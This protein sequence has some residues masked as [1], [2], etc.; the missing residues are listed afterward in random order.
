MGEKFKG[1]LGFF[2]IRIYLAI[3]VGLNL[4]VWLSAY[5]INKNISDD[6]AILHYNVDF[7][8]NLIGNARQIYIIPLLGLIIIL[9]NFFLF[10]A[11]YQRGIREIGNQ[12]KFL[13]NILFAAAGTANLFLFF[14][15]VSIYLINFF[16]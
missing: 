14:S 5:I 9:F 8:A 16:K 12:D 10:F 7:G 2:Y 1:L 15:L 4:L 11:I 13:A 3:I 6:L